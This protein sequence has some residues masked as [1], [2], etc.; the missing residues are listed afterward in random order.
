[1]TGCL[2]ILG[3]VMVISGLVNCLIFFPIGVIWGL[4][5]L[6]IGAFF[7]LLLAKA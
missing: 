6:L 7:L 3:V 4:P 5:I 2:A 1:M